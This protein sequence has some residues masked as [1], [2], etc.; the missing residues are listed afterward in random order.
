MILSVSLQKPFFIYVCLLMSSVG[1]CS[2][3]Y[4]GEVVKSTVSH[5][6]GVYNA[7]LVMQINA[8]TDKVYALFTDYDELARL[9]DNITDSELI[10]EDPPEYTV[11]V[12]THNCVLFFCKDL[13]Q[14]QQVLELGEGYIV[15]EDIKGQSDFIHAE[16]YWHIFAYKK[17]TRVTFNSEMKPGFWLPPLI[18]PWY[19]KKSLLQETKDMI[20]QLEKLAANDK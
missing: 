14:T 10:D 6:N 4:C 17:G 15:F 20:Q 12:K 8:P 18:G 11:I 3:A 9:S 16:S 13:T 7:S 1:Y 2:I 5:K 19:F